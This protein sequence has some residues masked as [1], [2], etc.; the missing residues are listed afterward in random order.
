MKPTDHITEI[1]KT[2]HALNKE[3]HILQSDQFVAMCDVIA[4]A[5]KLREDYY[6]LESAVHQLGKTIQW[7]DV[8]QQKDSGPNI[9]SVGE[10]IEE[11]N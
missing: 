4:L 1:L 11:D 10:V 6:N 3:G 7:H 5:E 8:P 2:I 9:T